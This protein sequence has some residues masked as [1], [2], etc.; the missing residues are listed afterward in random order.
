[1]KRLLI[2]SLLLAGLL[3][4][5][6]STYDGGPAQNISPERHGNLAAAQAYSAQAFDLMTAA[7]QAN[8]YQLGGHAAHAKDLLRQANDEMKLA[9]ETA[10]RRW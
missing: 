2:S 5:C 7:Q 1:M 10:N 8:E 3:G 6:A 9:A 4:G